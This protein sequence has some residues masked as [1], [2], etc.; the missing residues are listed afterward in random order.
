MTSI[1]ICHDKRLLFGLIAVL[2][3]LTGC[4]SQPALESEAA[5]E[6]PDTSVAPIPANATET[7]QVRREQAIAA[8][9]DYLKRYPASPERPQI[10]RRLADLMLD[11]AAELGVTTETSAGSA[12]Q[13]DVSR[14]ER[15]T[16][17]IEIYEGLLRQD[18]QAHTDTELLYQLARAY[19]EN[20]QPERAMAI[21]E[22]LIEDPG[23]AE[24]RLYAD[25][26]FRRG[27]IL[28]GKASF[29]LAENAYRAVVSLGDSVAVFEQAMYKLGWSLF[30]QGRYQDALQV[31]FSILDRKAP[32]SGSFSAY[33]S[34]LSSAEQE[35]V[36]DVLRA[37]S[38]CFS[39][40]A[41]PDSMAA[42]FS[43]H[44]GRT[45]ERRIYQDLAG[46]YERK[47]LFTDAAVT[48]LALAQRAP[49]DRR[50]PRLFVESIR[51]YRQAGLVN[52]VLEAQAAFVGGYGLASGFWEHRSVRKCPAVLAALQSSLVDLAAHYREL[53]LR[54][55]QEADYREAERWYRAYLA[56]FNDTQRADEMHYLLAELLF[57]VG[58]Y[59][60]A[61]V[62]F[63]RIAYRRT[64]HA[65]A[66]E[67]G[68][69]AIVAYERLE[70]R[71]DDADVTGESTRKMTSAIRFATT[72]SDHP[73][74][75][76][77]FRQAGVELLEQDQDRTAIQVCETLLQTAKPSSAG[78]RQV[79]WSVLAQA[80][81]KMGD[82]ANAEQAYREALSLTEP[83]DKRGDA[84]N[85]GMAAT[86]YKLAEEQRARGDERASAAL[87]LRAAKA[88]PGTSVAVTAEYDAASALLA[89]QQW[90]DAITVLEAFRA[91]YPAHPLQ[92]EATKK[93]AFAYIRD[94]RYLDA[95]AIYRQLG[96]GAGEDALRRSALVRAAELYEQ[97]G[98]LPQ[99]IEALA[100]YAREFPRPAIEVIEVYWKLAAF[101]KARGDTAQSRD[102][103]QRV[104]DAER[105][106]GG[107]GG[108]RMRTLAGKSTLELAG[109]KA[110]SF[111]RIRLVE[112]LQARLNEKLGAMRQA[113]NMLEAATAY[114][115]DSVSSAATYQIA[116]LYR[117]LSEA[118]RASERPAGVGSEELVQYERELEEQATGFEHKAIEI[119]Q[120]HSR[121]VSEGQS[122]RWTELSLKWLDEL[123]PKLAVEEAK[124]AP[125]VA[126]PK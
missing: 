88:A 50:A 101:E 126:A 91:D 77:V 67:A 49:Q 52:K 60:S 34:T 95:A 83:S 81:Y 3:L 7:I 13:R 120:T 15:L 108:V 62:E 27:E 97:G 53:A 25:A 29:Q 99:A 57:E 40:L 11:G 111:R 106:A 16:A 109:H 70:E 93:L 65:Q 10:Q 82:Y 69:A 4:T 115:I 44:E 8:Y 74:A 78:L 1:P 76:A 64:G 36:S 87:F 96:T 80:R 46:L 9:L 21:F 125:A 116:S 37:I 43:V 38:L 71:A 14:D 107:A 104:I 119:Y 19:D 2:A 102:W 122:D 121:R 58:Q 35:Q 110:G 56:W 90:Q 12:L 92:Q 75:A 31:F 45:Y 63:E 117:E 23:S 123:Q 100:Q 68:M 22:R 33:L 55:R 41:G 42:Y 112:P 84:L 79:A 114:Q 30:K 66:A 103:L 26:Q 20:A 6:R 118:L 113:L 89:S 98:D 17:A 32:T 61:A 105:L 85:K 39:Y 73:K 5:S 18:P 28:F 59:A 51:L 47:E 94:G 54:T 124:R 48:Y 24:N 72:Y 86:V